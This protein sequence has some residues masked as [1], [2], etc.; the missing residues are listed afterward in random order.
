[1]SSVAQSV[2]VNSGMAP[3]FLTNY[4]QV[5]A[6]CLSMAGRAPRTYAMD[7]QI[8]LNFPL[9]QVDTPYDVSQANYT[10][11][12]SVDYAL[13]LVHCPLYN[14]YTQA[15]LNALD[16]IRAGAYNIPQARLLEDMQLQATAQGMR[17]MFWRGAPGSTDE[18][19]LQ[20]PRSVITVLPADPDGHTTWSTYQGNALVSLMVSMIQGVLTATKQAAALNT[21]AFA[22]PVQLANYLK[23]SFQTAV[24]APFGNTLTVSAASNFIFRLASGADYEIPLYSDDMLV[25]PSTGNMYLVLTAAERVAPNDFL[26]LSGLR[27]DADYGNYGPERDQNA[28][29]SA[30][31]YSSDAIQQVTAGDALIIV[32][33]PS[34]AENVGFYTRKTC[35]PGWLLIPEHFAAYSAPWATT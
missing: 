14:I 3:G 16:E 31:Q 26:G 34:G 21:L 20:G 29:A 22:A 28:A 19:L 35:S 10:Q 27:K 12:P 2:L 30:S 23:Y 33:T 9:L 11:V 15:S 24:T 17:F 4:T 1:M 5:S 7:G 13:N 18:G 32:K 6:W 8:S 25:D